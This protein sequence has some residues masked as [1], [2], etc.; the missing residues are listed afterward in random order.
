MSMSCSVGLSDR[1]AGSGVS[2]AEVSNRRVCAIHTLLVVV[3]TLPRFIVSVA[4]AL[5]AARLRVILMCS[6][7]VSTNILATLRNALKTFVRFSDS[8]T[9]DWSI[10]DGTG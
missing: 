3:S 10:R 7:F 6:S 5:S 4:S 2:D 8:S 1:V 9:S